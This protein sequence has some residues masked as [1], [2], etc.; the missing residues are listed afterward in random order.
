MHLLNHLLNSLEEPGDYFKGRGQAENVPAPRNILLFIRH[1]QSALQQEALLNRS[2]HRFVLIY[3][4]KTVGRV[5]VDHL[6]VRLE[7]GRLMLIHPYEFHHF[8]Q[9]SSPS[10]QWLFCTF[11]LESGR[12]LEPLRHR[13]VPIQEPTRLALEQLVS[14]W[15]HP[16]AG[17]P[18]DSLLQVSLARLLMLCLVDL[19]FS[20]PDYP[21][22]PEDNLMQTVN[23]LLAEIRGR[24]VSVQDLAEA[25]G[26][27]ESG[28]RSR[29]QNAAGVPLGRYIQNY[30]INRAMALLRTTDLSIRDVGEEAGYGSPQSFSRSFKNETG[31]S[32]RSYRGR[33]TT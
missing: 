23:R 22:D 16:I 18:G 25:I 1:T 10:M 3:C 24:P 33:N 19:R 9:L 5:H 21:P 6:D 15:V 30:R 17:H 12:M 32:P 29:F 26:G 28:L 31:Q 4:L 8:S 2:H 13:S 11:E 20:A 27:S 14:D 7:P